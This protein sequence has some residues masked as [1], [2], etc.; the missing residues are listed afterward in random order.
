MHL[1]RATATCPALAK[2]DTWDLTYVWDVPLPSATYNVIV[3]LP[4]GLSGKLNWLNQPDQQTAAQAVVRLT[5]NTDV[6][7]GVIPAVGWSVA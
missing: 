6:A 7:G 1:S 5:I 4:A 2:G 3:S